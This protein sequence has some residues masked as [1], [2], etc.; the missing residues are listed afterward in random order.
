MWSTPIDLYCER[1]DPAFWSEPVNAISN[2]AF[3]IAAAAAFVAWRRS[4]V[5]DP[6]VLLLI[7]VVVLVGL[8]SFTFHTVAT[9]GAML[10]DVGPIGVFIYGYLLLA[11]RRF[12]HLSWALAIALLLSFIA[13]ST[14]VDSLVPRTF[15]NGSS[16]YLPAWAA[17]LIIGALTRSEPWGRALLAAA[18]VFTVSIGL[19][20]VDL[21]IC[22]AVPLGTHFLWHI[23]NAIVL[24][25]VLGGALE[26][27]R[28]KTP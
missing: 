17:L 24:Y 11:L 21:D 16:G 18:A 22:N 23:G 12:L 13:L 15:I 3:L 10:L 5:R 19:R 26:E 1:T 25:L 2:I 8:G 9:R 27:R 14:A 6:A 28:G 20:I 4:R 7:G